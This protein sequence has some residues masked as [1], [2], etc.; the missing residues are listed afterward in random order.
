MQ[1]HSPPMFRLPVCFSVGKSYSKGLD[2][3][4]GLVGYFKASLSQDSMCKYLSF[5]IICVWIKI[6]PPGDRRF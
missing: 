3:E 2:S 1:V 6:K 5:F 4:D